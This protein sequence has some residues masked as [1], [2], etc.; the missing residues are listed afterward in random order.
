MSEAFISIIPQYV[1]TYSEKF[2][3]NIGKI[4][5]KIR[6]GRFSPAFELKV[7]VKDK[8]FMSKE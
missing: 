6:I 8:G 4:D 1:P 3:W 5:Q 2:K 7:G